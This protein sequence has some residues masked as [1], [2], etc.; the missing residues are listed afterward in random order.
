MLISNDVNAVL[1]EQIGHALAESARYIAI[2]A[3]ES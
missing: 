2:A 1:D 3:Q